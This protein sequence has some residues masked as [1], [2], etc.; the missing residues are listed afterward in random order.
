MRAVAAHHCHGMNLDG[1]ACNTPKLTKPRKIIAKPFIRTVIVEF[2]SI[3]N[4]IEKKERPR[5]MRATLA[6]ESRTPVTHALI[7]LCA[8]IEHAS[9]D[10]K[11]WRDSA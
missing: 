2:H 10:N 3:S 4:A 8:G 7:L 6:I 9:D 5:R 1:F 11:A